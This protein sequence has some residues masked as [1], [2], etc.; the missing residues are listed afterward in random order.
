MAAGQDKT[1]S[2]RAFARRKPFPEHL[3]REH[4][5]VEAQ[6]T[7]TCCGS[8]RIVKISITDHPSW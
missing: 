3:L 8:D 6:T 2:I 1:S 7:C 5:V 4:V